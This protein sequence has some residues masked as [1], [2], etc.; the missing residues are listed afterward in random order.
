MIEQ[1]TPVASPRGEVKAAPRKSGRAWWLIPAGLVALGAAVG[2]YYYYNHPGAHA[3]TSPAADTTS[4]AESNLIEVEVVTPK[5][6]GLERT[7]VQPGDVRPFDWADLRARV[8]GYLKTQKVDIG[9][10]VEAGD[11][12]ATIDA[13]DRVQEYEQAKAYV[14][15]KRS[16]AD[17]A[18]KRVK[19]AEAAVE[20]AKAMVEQANKDVERYVAEVRYRKT[21]L[22]R[23][24]DLVARNA[25]EQRLLDEEREHYDEAVA[26]ERF[27]RA[28]VQ[29][30]TA[31][32]AKAEAEL[33]DAREEVKVADQQVK[34]AEA[35]RDKAKVY[36]D[37]T[38]I[39]SPYTG[40]VTHRSFHVGDFIRADT[41][42][43]A[44][45]ILTVARTDKMRVVIQVPDT[46][47]PFVHVGDKASIK[48]DALK[49]FPPF[50]GKVSRFANSE[51]PS[52][53]TMRTEV[54]LENPDNK[55]RE[56]MYGTATIVL[57]EKSP[58]N[59]TIPASAI[60]EQDEEGKAKLWVVREG[61][62]Q[63]VS[64]QVGQNNGVDVEVLKGELR[65]DDQVVALATG[66]LTKD[67]PVKTTEYR[68]KGEVKE[69]S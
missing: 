30:R 28:V 64:V 36:V 4:A 32:R 5:K 12:L 23:V 69:S 60:V 35:E 58:D 9:D 53:R 6:G 37:F 21:A 7:T 27:S 14:G 25:L 55:L 33:E 18:R 20:A 42:G 51:N 63:E 45:P 62:A 54:D 2:G 1:G 59:L 57:L 16:Q 15:L 56:G 3:A 38:E 10:H 52:N 61:K 29:T 47:V 65:A 44:V 48:I 24:T 26:A 17:L 67:L 19:S 49:Y 66:G 41:E 50:K 68:P 39:R 31:E 11:V 40:V 22:A 13:P 34:I 43:T 46:D 8:S